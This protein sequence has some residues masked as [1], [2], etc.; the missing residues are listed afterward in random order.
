MVN[1]LADQ[2]Q[3]YRGTPLLKSLSKVGYIL[4]DVLLVTDDDIG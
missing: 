2:Q 4:F 1:D 3:Y